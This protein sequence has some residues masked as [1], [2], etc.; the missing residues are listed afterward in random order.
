VL[1][2]DVV[3]RPVERPLELGEEALSLVGGDV[4]PDVLVAAVVD[5]LVTAY[6]LLANL[7]VAAPLVVWMVDV[8]VSICSLSA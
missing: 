8:D 7:D 2:T 6:E 1:P 5:G 4:A 3:V